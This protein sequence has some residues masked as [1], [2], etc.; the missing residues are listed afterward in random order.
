VSNRPIRI[1]LDTSAIIMFCRS[2]IH[3]GEVIAEI[4]DEQAAVCVPMLCLV[5]ASGAAFDVDRLELLVNNTASLILAPDPGDWRALAALRG[6]VGRLDAASAVLAAIDAGC[7][8]LTSQ[9]GLYAG[10]AGGGPIIE[11]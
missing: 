2:I 3:V 4:N 8:V 9:P 6:T 10:L 7:Q 1:I 5:E 11:I